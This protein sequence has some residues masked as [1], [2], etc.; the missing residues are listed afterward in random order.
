MGIVKNKKRYSGLKKYNKLVSTLVKDKKKRKESYQISDIRALASSIYPNF[1][2]TPLKSL[3]KRDILS[4]KPQKLLPTQ[5]NYIAEEEPELVFPDE[6]TDLE[7]RYYFDIYKM[8]GTIEAETSNNITFIS[9]VEGSEDLEFQGGTQLNPSLDIFYQD[10]F[11]QFVKYIDILRNE[12]KIDYSSIRVI[13]TAPE[14]KKGKYISYI[15]VTN[16]DGEEELDPDLKNL[17]DGFD[18]NKDY[19]VFTKKEETKPTPPEESKKPK[20]KIDELELAKI[21]A[22]ERIE[23]ERLKLLDKYYQDALKGEKNGGISWERYDKM[24]ADLYRKK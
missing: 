1:K 23:M 6:L 15:I 16:S 8:L 3:R 9:K 5:R 10:N 7:E 17:L 24:I 22:Q 4:A 12:N 2:E 11:S 19:S 13:C 18:P 14:K 21:Q 20:G